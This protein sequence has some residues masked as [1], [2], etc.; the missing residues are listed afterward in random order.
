VAPPA[1]WHVGGFLSIGGS[2]MTL[3]HDTV[4]CTIPTTYANTAQEA[5]CSGDINLIPY[6]DPPTVDLHITGAVIQHNL[7][8]GSTDLAFCTYGGTKIGSHGANIVYRDNVFQRG[9]NGKCGAY[10]PVTG[11]ETGNPGNVWT[12]NTWDSGGQVP[13]AL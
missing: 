12:N 4:G 6:Y 9:S 5:G 10:G 8:E 11:Y 2:N 13:P 7:L 1:S 3:T